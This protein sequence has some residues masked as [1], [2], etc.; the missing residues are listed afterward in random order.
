MEEQLKDLMLARKALELVHQEKARLL[1]EIKDTERYQSL[2]REEFAIQTK[3]TDL[4]IEIRDLAKGRYTVTGDKKVAPGVGI[5]ISKAPV[6]DFGAAFAWCK[7]HL[8]NALTLDVKLFEK[9]A[10]A[11]AAT[12]PVPIVEWEEVIGVTIASDL[13]KALAGENG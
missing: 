12:Q 3:I 10:A 1:Q 5:R 11:V 8:P 4:G 9:H 6:Y 13:E 2:E 7:E